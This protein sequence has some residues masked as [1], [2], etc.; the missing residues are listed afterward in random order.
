MRR[1]AIT[2]AGAGIGRALAER[3]AR[4]GFELLLIDVDRDAGERLATSPSARQ[5]GSYPPT[6]PAR[7]GS[8]RSSA[9]WTRRRS[10]SSST[11]RASAASGASTPHPGPSSGGS[12]R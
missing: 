5:P 7:T 6:W 2:G 4:E 3:F 12:W 9:D 11:M 1:C 10:T 8:T